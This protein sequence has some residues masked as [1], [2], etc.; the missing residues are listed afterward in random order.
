MK[1]TSDIKQKI[2]EEYDFWKNDLWAG[3]D[4]AARAKLGQFAT[5][6]ELVFK[7]L[8][9]F[10]SLEDKDILDPCLGAGNLIAGAVIAGADPKRCYG[11]EL[12]PEVL[13]IAKQRL[14]ALGVP[15]CNLKC[16][17]AL[18]SDAYKFGPED[19]PVVHDQEAVYIDFSDPKRCTAMAMEF[20]AT[21]TAVHKLDIS[22]QSGRVLLQS[23]IDNAARNGM[24]AIFSEKTPLA[25][26]LKKTF[27]MDLKALVHT[28]EEQRLNSYD[29]LLPFIDDGQI[30]DEQAEKKAAELEAAVTQVECT[31]ANS[32]IGRTFEQLL[33]GNERMSAGKVWRAWAE[34]AK[35]AYARY[36]AWKVGKPKDEVRAVHA[37]YRQWKVEQEAK[38]CK[39][40]NARSPNDRPKK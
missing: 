12:D 2:Q 37:A 8:E 30:D 36:N 3:K 40:F 38:W 33:A 10:G 1:L 19:K 26:G 23:F 7:M 24:W 14:G 29:D 5:P 11:I 32:I 16:G 35:Q 28:A 6:P 31:D 22:H 27:I 4:K 20:P 25:D 17:N 34:E 9:K 21:P 15:A 13:E 39:H 18:D